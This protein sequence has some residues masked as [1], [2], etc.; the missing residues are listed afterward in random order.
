[1]IYHDIKI[2]FNT[3]L[4]VLIITNLVFSMTIRVVSNFSNNNNKKM[5]NRF[6]FIKKCPFLNRLSVNEVLEERNI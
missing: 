4:I 2:C 5:Q 6:H 1:M 3:H